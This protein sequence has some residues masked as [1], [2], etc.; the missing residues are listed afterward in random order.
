MVPD[1]DHDLQRW[2]FVWCVIGVC[3]GGFTMAA[4][5]RDA[6]ASGKC[7]LLKS[8]TLEY[9]AARSER[10][11]SGL[12]VQPG[13]TATLELVG[14]EAGKRFYL[15]ASKAGRSWTACTT[16]GLRPREIGWDP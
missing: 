5:P 7:Q 3:I 12:E 11:F 8:Y 15:C 13:P 14:G 4:G 6:W 16:Q 10:G 1:K 2:M 9:D